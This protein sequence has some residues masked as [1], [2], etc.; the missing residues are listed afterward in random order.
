MP[1]AD[2]RDGGYLVLRQQ[3]PDSPWDGVWS[4]HLLPSEDGGTRMLIRS[5]TAV[6]A[7]PVARL[8]GVLFSPIADGVTALM[9]LGMLAGLRERA[10]RSSESIRSEK[11]ETA[12]T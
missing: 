7:G 2:L 3:P 6:P 11:R 9:E 5:R 12:A 4:F 1:V 8:V 10:E